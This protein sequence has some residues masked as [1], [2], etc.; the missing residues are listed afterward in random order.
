[1]FLVNSIEPRPLYGEVSSHIYPLLLDSYLY[2]YRVANPS[3]NNL[4]SICSVSNKSPGRIKTLLSH[5]SAVLVNYTV[6]ILNSNVYKHA[7]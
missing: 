7:D 1:M 2:R 3:T 5:Q 4:L 6:N